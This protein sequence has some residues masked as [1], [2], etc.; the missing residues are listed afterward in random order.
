MSAFSNA[1][2]QIALQALE[3]LPI[4][5]ASKMHNTLEC[6]PGLS[7][8]LPFAMQNK[9]FQYLAALQNW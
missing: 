8:M 6:A 4:L 5:R 7:Q 3:V 1:A 2:V 9:L